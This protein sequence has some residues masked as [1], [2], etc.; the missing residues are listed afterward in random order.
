MITGRRAGFL[1]S[2]M[3]E[4]G[5]EMWKYGLTCQWGCGLQ[6]T[7]DHDSEH[8]PSP[9]AF[10]LYTTFALIYYLGAAAWAVTT[11]NSD[12]IGKHTLSNYFN[13]PSV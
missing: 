12:E 6:M 11:Y 5:T 10:L 4:I 7:V 1:L 8:S 13:G 3:K 9:E 2:T